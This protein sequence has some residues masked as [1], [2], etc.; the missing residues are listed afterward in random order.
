MKKGFTLAEVLITLAIIG[1]VATLTLPALITNTGEQQAKT[2]FK[3]GI[4]TL[5]EAAQ[6]NK[7]LDGFDYSDIMSSDTTRTDYTEPNSQSLY[8]LLATR[9]AID[10]RASGLNTQESHQGAAANANTGNFT[11]FF[12]DG[13]SLSYNAA[14]SVS[15]ATSGR[16]ANNVSQ[17]DG[18]P[19]GITAIYDTNGIKGP[20]VVSNC[21]SASTGVADD[22]LPNGVDLRDRCTKASRVIKDQFGIRLRGSYAVPNGAAAQWAY[23][24]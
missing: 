7:T 1:V 23:N 14:N 15:T 9:T 8:A 17:N 24:N 5:T 19:Y 13:S 18:L 20:N 2:A 3:K 10:H 16:V 21:R 12:R 11:V 4:N 22:Q 6:M